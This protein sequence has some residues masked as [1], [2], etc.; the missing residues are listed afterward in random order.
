LESESCC[1][2]SSVDVQDANDKRIEKI[3]RW[4]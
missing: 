2:C 3:F 1:Q 4:L